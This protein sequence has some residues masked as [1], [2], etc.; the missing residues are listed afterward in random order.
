MIYI[1]TSTKFVHS[2]VRF[3]LHPQ[4]CSPRDAATINPKPIC[5]SGCKEEEKGE[6]NNQVCHTKVEEGVKLKAVG[7][8]ANTRY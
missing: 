3:C 6:R 1:V 5:I 7:D 2:C 8:P 4:C